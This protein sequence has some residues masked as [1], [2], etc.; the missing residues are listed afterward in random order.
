MWDRLFSALCPDSVCSHR[1]SVRHREKLCGRRRHA[2]AGDVAAP[3]A[4]RRDT[5]SGGAS[6]T[7]SRRR[8][9]ETQPNSK[10]KWTVT[11]R[12]VTQPVESLSAVMD[13]LAS[14]LFEL[15]AHVPIHS[16]RPLLFYVLPP[17]VFSLCFSCV[18]CVFFVP[19]LFPLHSS[20]AGLR[21]DS[22]ELF[23][24]TVLRIW[25]MSLSFTCFVC[26]PRL[27]LVYNTFIPSL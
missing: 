7:L 3:L 12:L 1:T 18:F 11:E 20:V 16:R 21:V 23:A 24:R 17:L 27:S 8:R 10:L 14:K 9:E 19:L 5:H 4:S 26:T 6:A 22:T 2:A 15:E 13:P 25:S